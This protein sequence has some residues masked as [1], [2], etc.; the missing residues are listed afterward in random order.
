MK[1]CGIISAVNPGEGFTLYVPMTDTRLLDRWGTTECTVDIPDPRLITE[2]QRGK[3]FALV[4]DITAYIDGLSRTD[5]GKFDRAAQG[6]LN[7]MGLL[8]AAE[9][10]DAEAVRYQLT[11]NYC[12]L[13]GSFTFSLS[14]VDRT[15]AG[16]FIDWLV[17]FCVVHGIPCMDTLLNRCE[18]VGRYVYACAANKRCCLSGQK[19][20]LHHVDAVGMG[21]SRRDIVHEGMRV[22]P[23]SRTLHT[24]AHTIGKQTFL[25]K[26]HIAPLVL[27]ARLC[28]VWN[29]KGEQKHG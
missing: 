14:S 28:G 29:V 19:A 27:D 16:D 10:E 6:M 3:I 25:N 20:E 12:Q 24:E 4:S 26:Y 13:I 11:Y 8:Y 2:R 15:T 21:R 18:D 5:K 7:C 1:T 9:Y 22:L 23:L 17:E